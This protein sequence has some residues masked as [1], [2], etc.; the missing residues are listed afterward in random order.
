MIRGGSG[1][2]SQL[3][4]TNP[5]GVSPSYTARHHG[6]ASGIS[7]ASRSAPATDP[8]NIFCPGATSR[9]STA[10]RFASVIWRRVTV[11]PSAYA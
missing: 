2:T 8:T 9:A 1:S 10:S 3:S 6:F 4:I 7:S 5:T 11:T